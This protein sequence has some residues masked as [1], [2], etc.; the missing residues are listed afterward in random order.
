MYAAARRFAIRRPSGAKIRL[1]AGVTACALISACANPFGNAK[2]D[3][4][5]PIAADVARVANAHEPYPTFASIPPIPKDLRPVKA[6]G[7]EARSVVDARNQLDQETAPGA[8]TLDS[9]DDFAAAARAAA[10]TQPPQAAPKANGGADD[11]ADTQ[12][13]RATPPPPPPK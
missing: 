8:W 13:K 6:Y 11:F 12:R 10:G 7:R 1:A 2:V 4:N 9:A 3:P 5:S